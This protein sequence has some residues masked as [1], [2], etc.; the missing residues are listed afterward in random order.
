MVLMVLNFTHYMN[1]YVMQCYNYTPSAD[2]LMVHFDGWGPEYNYWCSR[3]SV[4]LH[5]SG[6]CQKYS[7]DLQKPL[8]EFPA[9]GVTLH[10]FKYMYMQ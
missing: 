9:N 8:S 10:A 3:N 5:P 4:E 7:W 1:R 2:E 6:W